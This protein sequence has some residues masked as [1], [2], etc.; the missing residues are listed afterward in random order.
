MCLLLPVQKVIKIMMVNVL[1]L[2]IVVFYSRKHAHLQ[3]LNP[4]PPIHQE[5]YMASQPTLYAE[6]HYGPIN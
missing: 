1:I 4:S 2:I 5:A 3:L 6:P